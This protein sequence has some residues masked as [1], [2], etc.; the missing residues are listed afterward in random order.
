MINSPYTKPVKF[1]AASNQK[2]RMLDRLKQSVSRRYLQSVPKNYVRTEV[3][4]GDS[5]GSSQGSKETKRRRIGGGYAF[6][7]DGSSKERQSTYVTNVIFSDYNQI[8]K[9]KPIVEQVEEDKS[10]AQALESATKVPSRSRNT[11]IGT[12]ATGDEQKPHEMLTASQPLTRT[13]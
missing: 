2:D 3:S 11:R 4:A 1:I 13:A 10:L 6:M 8:K 5:H 7:S 9:N 12:Y